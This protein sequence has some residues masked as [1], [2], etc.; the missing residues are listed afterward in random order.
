[1]WGSVIDMI[2]QSQCCGLASGRREYILIVTIRTL[3]TRPC[4]ETTHSSH[5][6][7]PR[8]SFDQCVK[9]GGM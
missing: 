8:R 6:S 2:G 5:I 7:I 1:M 3:H 4:S 9:V